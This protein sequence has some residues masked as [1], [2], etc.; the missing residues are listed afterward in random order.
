[1]K[2]RRFEKQDG[3]KR[4]VCEITWEGSEVEVATGAVGRAP[5]VTSRT[6]GVGGVEAFIADT[7]KRKLREGFVE[8]GEAGVSLEAIDPKEAPRRKVRSVAHEAFALVRTE[9]PPE[10]EAM[11]RVG[12]P[13]LLLAG[14]E[15]PRCKMCSGPLQFLAQVR[16]Q[17][18]LIAIF[19]CAQNPGSCA[20]DSATAGANRAIV[21]RARDPLAP[22][23]PPA[24]AHDVL[25]SRVDG[26][27]LVRFEY[28]TYPDDP[29][30]RD[31]QDD[32][33]PREDL[34]ARYVELRRRSRDIIGLIGPH[35]DWVQHEEIPSC[36]CGKPMRFLLQ[37][38]DRAGGGINFGDIGCGYVFACDT[39]SE[40]LFL[41]QCH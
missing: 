8:V 34:G 26:V 31:R 19:Q 32:D 28:R 4:S 18:R 12:G 5:R 36:R 25:L 39:C 16:R 27:E 23:A 35:A 13:P 38:E 15:W 3:A 9:P 14:S 17:H 6:C 7:V 41:W 11:T 33:P 30:G 29:D 2:L 40:A 22:L 20:S 10:H 21:M 37:L 24:D 1:V